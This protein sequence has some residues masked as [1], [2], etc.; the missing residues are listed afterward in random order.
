M[1]RRPS[2]TIRTPPITDAVKLTNRV[3][4]VPIGIHC[5]GAL[6][7]H[8]SGAGFAWLCFL[9]VDDDV[10][11]QALLEHI[12][13]DNGYQVATA[14]SIATATELLSSQPSISPSAMSTL[15]D[16]AGS[17]SPIGRLP[18]ASKRL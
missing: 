18:R 3:A 5:R 6:G 1:R 12:L 17:P 13:L 11:A 10:E 7:L 15:A 2:I 9:L 14:E 4:A 8:H 16:G